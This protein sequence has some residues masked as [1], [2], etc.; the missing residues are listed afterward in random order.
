MVDQITFAL[1]QQ[2]L[3]FSQKKLENQGNILRNIAGS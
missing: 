1:A 3:K 2:L